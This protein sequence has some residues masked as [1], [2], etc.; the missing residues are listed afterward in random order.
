MEAGNEDDESK[1]IDFT[2]EPSGERQ[3]QYQLGL[4]I[5]FLPELNLKWFENG[6][7]KGK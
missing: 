5:T 4:K 6:N 1:L 2:N 3:F 7:V